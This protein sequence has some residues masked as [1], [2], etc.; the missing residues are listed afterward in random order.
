MSSALVSLKFKE[1]AWARNSEPIFVGKDV[2]E[3]LSSSMY[4]DPLS[5]YREYIQN[6]ADAYDQ[7][8]E[9]ESPEAEG[10]IDIR[11]DPKERRIVITDLGYGLEEQA[12]YQRLTSIGGSGK[13]GTGARGFRGVGRL[14]GLAYC[15]EL[16]FRTRPRGKRAIQEMRWDSRKI[17]ELLRSD[18]TTLDLS[19]VVSESVETRTIVGADAP[20]HFFEVELRGVVRHGNDR[21]LDAGEVM[22]YLSQVAPVPFHPDFSFGTKILDFLRSH[23][24]HRIPLEIE[25]AGAGRVFRPHRDQLSLG[26]DKFVNFTNL[27]TFTT[28]DRNG[29][30]STASW[31]LHHGYIGALS[32]SSI[33][34]GWRL[35]S[36]DIQVGE[37]NLIEDLYPESRFN[38]WTVAESHILDRKII[39]NGRRD[40]FEHNA[41]FAD[42][43]TRLTPHA[44]NIAQLCRVSSITRNLRARIDDEL[45]KCEEKVSIAAKKRTP[46]AVVRALTSD[47]RSSLDRL[48]PLSKRSSVSSEERSKFEARSKTL[49]AKLSTLEQRG[50]TKETLAGFTPLQRRLLADVFE[51]IYESSKSLPFADELIGKIISTVRKKG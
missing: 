1:P 12:F 37:T 51:V 11:I 20:E 22:R 34:S 8:H 41:Y 2:L 30:P 45:V 50:E 13:R 23:K 5:M 27:E 17:R 42:L 33:V 40:N 10:R 28:Q 35:R 44:R 9:E 47:V 31:I 38:S 19:Q 25:I 43:L 48:E 26:N 49:R 6:A 46:G 36:G 32:K 3:L 24:A 4:V 18:D 15:Q 14:A 21:L 29:N 16:I 39:P 7:V